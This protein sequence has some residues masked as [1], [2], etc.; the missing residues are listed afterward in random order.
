MSRSRLSRRIW[1]ASIAVAALGAG[2]V[3]SVATSA[4]AATVPQVTIGTSVNGIAGDPMYTGLNEAVGLTVTNNST[5][6]AKLGL[7]TIVIPAGYPT[8]TPGSVSPS[9]WGETYTTKCGLVKNCSA[10]IF[11]APKVPLASAL[12]PVGGS[13]TATFSFT[14]PS[15]AQTLSFPVIGIGLGNGVFTGSGNVVVQ[16]IAAGQ[17]EILT[18]GSPP[19]VPLS[20]T[21]PS[22]TNLP[23]TNAAAGLPNGAVGG[24]VLTVAPCT[25]PACAQ[26]APSPSG[27]DEITPA[28]TSSTEITLSGIFTDPKLGEL[29]TDTA[30]GSVSWTCPNSKCPHADSV[31]SEGGTNYLYNFGATGDEEEQ[32]E[33]YLA[34]PVYVGIRDPQTQSYVFSPNPAPACRDNDDSEQAGQTGQI[35]STAAVAAGYCVDVYAMSRTD[36]S[37]TGDLTMTL[38]FVEDPKLRTT[39]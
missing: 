6:K 3:L 20:V 18:P 2:T 25:D 23:V 37:F 36:N 26:S 31:E 5:T 17:A 8:V 21:V 27:D 29:Y 38:L 32:Y 22:G 33:D 35:V 16:A 13:V 15:S 12:I 39:P 7:F 30:P 4:P 19:K 34:Y 24:T 14:A 10:L 9:T 11:V 1:I 28:S